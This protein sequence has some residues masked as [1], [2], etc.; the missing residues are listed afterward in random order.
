MGRGRTTANPNIFSL[1]SRGSYLQS[2]FCF[3]ELSPFFFFFKGLYF[4][5]ENLCSILGML[6]EGTH[7]VKE[8]C[9]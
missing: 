3:D 8:F 4:F 7:L 1:E 2:N 9:F 6:S 5:L